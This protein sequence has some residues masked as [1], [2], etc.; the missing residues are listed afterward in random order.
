MAAG[1]A[2]ARGGSLGRIRSLLSGSAGGVM[3]MVLGSGIGQLIALAVSPLLTRLYTI[4][5][6]GL[7]TIFVSITSITG[8]FV[9]FRL[10]SAIPLPESDRIAASVAWL[11]IGIGAV[12]SLVI[13][14]LGPIVAVPVAQMV[15]IPALSGV[16]WWVAAATFAVVLDQ[17]LLTWM[18]REQRYK[19]LAARNFLQG[20]GQ[21]GF[22]VGFGYV[23]FK[24]VGLLIGWIGGRIVALGGLFS[25]GGLFTQGVPKLADLRHAA[26]RYRRFPLVASWAALLNV[27][28]QQ[29]PFLVL[30]A[31]YGAATV[32]LLSVTLR[33]L[34]APV[35]LIGQAVA[36]VF[37]GEASAAIRDGHTPLRPIIRSNTR[38]LIL[39]SLPLAV[40]LIA[41]APPLFAFVFGAEWRQAGVYTQ[42]LAL[43]Y[44][45]QLIASPISQT[46]LIL[47]RQ[48]AQLAWDASR[49]V[50]TVGG[51]LL[52]AILGAS[53]TVAIVTLS[54]AYVV[55]YGALWWTCVRVAGRY[56]QSLARPELG[57]T[58][59]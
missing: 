48:G 18:V 35:T 29:A 54:A 10:E 47:E 51:P 33:V 28:G 21:G 12:G 17:V 19:A 7:F 52:V 40:L 36:R 38:A 53:A 23:P 24:S 30:G 42:I 2:Q 46:L 1:E 34:S 6:F 9:L 50:I 37:Q 8:T 58:A 43:G 14:L 26:S 11:G 55:C 39:I 25:E 44:A 5:E 4:D 59:R 57:D 49:M 15:G 27:L 56:D 22:Q 3:W 16:W 13:G 41:V 32:G 20:A 31:F 45:A